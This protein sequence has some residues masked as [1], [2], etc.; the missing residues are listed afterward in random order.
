VKIIDA[1]LT[2]QDIHEVASVCAGAALFK[3]SFFDD[4]GLFDER[5]FAVFEDVDLSLRGIWR[6][7]KFH[8]APSAVC[9]HHRSY[10]LHKMEEEKKMFIQA[11]QK[12]NYLR[13]MTKNYPLFLLLPTLIYIMQKD[14][15]TKEMFNRA[16]RTKKSM[17]Y[18]RYFSDMTEMLSLRKEICMT[19]RISTRVFIRNFRLYS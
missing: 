17:L 18:R 15:I 9:Y 5:F 8:F 13:F 4:V 2:R 11:C 7:W 12:Y 14:I 16:Y 1:Q 6:G 19:R 10:S 3:R